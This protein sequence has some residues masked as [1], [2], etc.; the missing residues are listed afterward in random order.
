MTGGLNER[1]RE[2][3]RVRVRVCVWNE[4]R[5]HTNVFTIQ[6]I[7]AVILEEKGMGGT[8]CC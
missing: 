3:G 8:G 1:G 4:F 6:C 7:A 2:R 5:A